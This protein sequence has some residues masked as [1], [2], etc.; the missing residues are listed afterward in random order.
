MALSPAVLQSKFHN[1]NLL[2]FLNKVPSTNL[3][4]DGFP[5][6]FKAKSSTYKAPQACLESKSPQEVRP[7]A[8]FPPSL[9]GNRFSSIN[10]NHSEFET[11]DTQ[12]KLL[13]PKIRNMLVTSTSDVMDKII[14]IDTLCRLGV[15]YHFEDVI[16][17]E[18]NQIFNKQPH[19]L[20]ENEY[21]LY[22]VSL[23]FRAFRQHGFK[24]SCDVFNKFKDSDGK[25]KSSLLS[26]VKG[27]LSLYEATHLSLPGEDIL[28][29]ALAFTKQYLESSAVESFPNLGSHII[30]ALEQP[31]HNGVPRLEARKFID[32]YEAGESPNQ[33]LLEFAKLDYNRVQLLHQQELNHFSKRWKELNIASEI[34][35][36]RDRMAEIFFWAVATYYEP[37]YAHVRMIIAKVVLLISLV[38]DTIDAYAT[39]DETHRL[40]A[41]IERWDMSCVDELP[42]YMK[43]IYKLLLDTFNEFENDLKERKESYSVKFGREAFQELVRG[44][45][46]E[47]LWRDEGKVPSFDEYIYNGSMTTGL[48]LVTTVSYM[49]VEKIK[50]TEEFEWLQ[51]NPKLNH[52]SGAFIRLVNDLTFHKTEQERGHVASCI[53]CYVKQ[54]GVSKEEA[55]KVLQKMA[56]DCWKEINEEIMRP[57]QVS[58]DLLMRVVNLVRFTDVSYKYGDG[59]TDSQQLKQFVKGLFVDPIFI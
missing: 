10:I 42:D 31:F 58:V 44:Y 41:A 51:T 46:L 6:S 49:G 16:E 43:I 22:T 21:D 12:V 34:P 17:E 4:C 37:H 38:D 5:F 8:N 2:P 45:Y 59:Y 28:D 33:T 9:W 56:T 19:F 32:F 36:A 35:Y 40:A 18:L 53:D 3:G 57:T 23:A 24:M 52:V 25:F 11:Y 48:P 39:I 7:L 55:V 27:M 47:A 1:Q 50:G 20:D 30:N 54:Y 15:S 26:D 14:L 29:Q 13:T